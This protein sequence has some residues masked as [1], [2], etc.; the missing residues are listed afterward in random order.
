MKFMILVKASAGSEAGEMPDEALLTAMGAYNQQLVDAGVMLA[1]EGLQPTSKGARVRFS[2][3]ERTVTEGP[4]PLTGDL[5]AGFWIWNVKSK[6]EAIDWVKKC[7]NPMPG[8]V[9][10][11]EIR[12]IFAAEDFTTATPEILEQEAKLRARVE[13]NA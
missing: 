6:Q 11:L 3:D 7:P 12:Q 1:G 10:E 5:L 9:T 4:F 2:G 8:Q 13:G